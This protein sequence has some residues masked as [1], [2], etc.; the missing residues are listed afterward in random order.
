VPQHEHYEA[1]YT[2]EF[3]EVVR[4]LIGLRRRLKPVVVEEFGEARER[5]HKLLPRDMSWDRHDMDLFY[6]VGG[7]LIYR[8][9]AMTMGELSQALDVPLSTTTRIVDHLV[10]NEYAQRLPDPEDRRVVR[11][12]LSETGRELFE[13]LEQFMVAR[14]QQVLEHFTP[15]EQET[16][17]TLLRKLLST[18]N[19]D[20]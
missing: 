10:K 6:H 2:A 18:L 19:E 17:L 4:G 5:F 11:V 9:H 16:L 3:I 7:L 8:P 15:D 12:T 20:H 14:V 13:G 1:L